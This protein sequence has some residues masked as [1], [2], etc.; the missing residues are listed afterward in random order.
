[1]DIQ[2]QEMI[3]APAEWIQRMQLR[4][5]Y[6]DEIIRCTHRVDP[7]DRVVIGQAEKVVTLGGILIE[8]GPSEL[9]VWVC[10]LPFNHIYPSASCNP[11]GLIRELCI[12]LVILFSWNVR[13]RFF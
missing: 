7:R 11:N 9:V 12:V 13:R 2:T 4:T 3:L 1:M 10:R 6:Q 8:P 5:L